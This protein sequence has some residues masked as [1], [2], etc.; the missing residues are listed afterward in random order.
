MAIRTTFR[1][2]STGRFISAEQARDI[3]EAI[4]MTVSG[5]GVVQEPIQFFQDEDVESEG[6]NE[7][8]SLENSRWG[9]R[10]T[11]LAGPLDASRLEAT[12]FP[13]G[14][15]AFRVTYVVDGNPNYSKGFASSEWLG[16]SEW[17]PAMDL[18][19]GVEP[20]GIGHIVFRRSH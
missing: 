7:P 20:D 9:A 18:L 13:A 12:D 11:D 17:P 1:D 15:D 6:E 2:P 8:Y 16:P 3:G 4:R 10:M 19:E 5:E 14:F